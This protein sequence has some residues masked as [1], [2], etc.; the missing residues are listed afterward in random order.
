MMGLLQ[1]AVAAGMTAA[2]IVDDELS[3]AIAEC[4]SVLGGVING[5]VILQL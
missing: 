3:V 1:L 5:E 4:G 2:G